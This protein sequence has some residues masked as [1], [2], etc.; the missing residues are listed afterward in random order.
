MVTRILHVSRDGTQE[1]CCIS[2]VF[3]RCD[4]LEYE[5]EG[6]TSLQGLQRTPLDGPRTPHP[7][8]WTKTYDRRIKEESAQHVSKLI[9]IRV[10]SMDFHHPTPVYP[11]HTYHLSW[12]LKLFSFTSTSS[13]NDHNREENPSIS[14]LLL[15][16]SCTDV[17][18]KTK[19]DVSILCASLISWSVH[20]RL[21]CNSKM[22]QNRSNATD[23]NTVTTFPVLIE[24]GSTNRV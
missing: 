6:P 19:E 14:K 22:L 17:V 23:L 12:L 10:V 5:G 18:Q 15:M 7:E 1:I 21:Y 11:N 20:I 4:P 3:A 2:A 9:M 8:N 24:S 13:K 16:Q